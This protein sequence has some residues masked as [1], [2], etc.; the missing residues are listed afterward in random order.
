MKNRVSALYFDSLYIHR[1][2]LSARGEVKISAIV[3]HDAT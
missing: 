2:I 3:Q 1:E